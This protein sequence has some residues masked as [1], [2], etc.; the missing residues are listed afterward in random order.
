[1][2]LA[3]LRGLSLFDGLDDDQ[4]AALLAASTEHVM[5]RGE[6]LFHEGRPADCWWVLLEGSIA[7][8]RQVGGEESTLGAMT[9]PGQWAGGFGAWDEHGVYFATAR[10]ATSATVLRLSATDLKR[11]ADAWFPFGVHFINGLVSTV[12]RIESGARQREALVALGTL[13]AGLAR[14]AY[15]VGVRYEGGRRGHMLAFMAAVPGAAEALARATAE[16][17][18]FSGLE[19]GEIDVAF[20]DLSDP[21]AARLARVGLRFDLPEPAPVEL[22]EVTAPGMDPAKPPRLR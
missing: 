21:I 22:R 12:R 6:L 13:A 20:F 2:D 3:E 16:A 17:L 14:S 19:A 4:L 10:A 1:M 9:D 5:R 7:L 8:V 18:V 11:C 15:L